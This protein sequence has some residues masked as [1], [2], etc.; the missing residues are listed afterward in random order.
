MNENSY[1]RD[2]TNKYTDTVEK[3]IYKYANHPSILL[4]KNNTGGITPFLFKEAS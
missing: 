2:E 1:I 4:I 3:G